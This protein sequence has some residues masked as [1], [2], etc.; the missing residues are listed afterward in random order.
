MFWSEIKFLIYFT[1]KSWI[2]LY[3]QQCQK[4]DIIDQKV[5]ILQIYVTEAY[6]ADQI[7]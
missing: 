7:H 4:L 6:K 2:L 1:I 5:F 3:N